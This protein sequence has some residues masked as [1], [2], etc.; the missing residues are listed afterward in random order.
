MIGDN[1]PTNIGL[2]WPKMQ[3]M[4]IPY[5]EVTADVALYEEA[6]DSFGQQGHSYTS[7]F[8]EREIVHLWSVTF[9]WYSSWGLAIASKYCTR[10]NFET[11]TLCVGLGMF[12]SAPNSTYGFAVRFF[13]VGC[14][15]NYNEVPATGLFSDK[16]DHKY[17]CSKCGY[18][19]TVNSSG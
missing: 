11:R 7:L 9:R 6:R 3:V 10:T 17:L 5:K 19:Y 4:P 12:A 16:F 13:V 14:E 18:T 2:V 1:P 15:H 8:L